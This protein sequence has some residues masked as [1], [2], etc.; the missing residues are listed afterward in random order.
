MHRAKLRPLFPLLLALGA[1]CSGLS[2]DSTYAE[3]VDFK[4]LRTYDW[5]SLPATASTA[6]N[7]ETVAG[8]LATTLE[9]KGLT[10]SKE[11]P[12]LL[13]AVHRTLEGSGRM[14]RYALTKGSLVIDLVLASSKQ[15]VWRGV[16]SG[17]FRA[18]QSPEER[19]EFL[20]GLIGAMFADYPP[21]G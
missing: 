4:R 12:D 14:E 11:N 18:D 2:V 3:G 9:Q 19:R 17:A 13:I 20:K 15:S 7:D 16:A 8:V 6:A 1:G 10:R 21:G 5:M